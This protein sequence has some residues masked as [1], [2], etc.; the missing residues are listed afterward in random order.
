MATHSSA[1]IS[2]PRKKTLVAAPAAVGRLERALSQRARGV[3]ALVRVTQA[4]AVAMS[5]LPSAQAEPALR[6]LVSRYRSHLSVTEEGELVYAF[7]PRLERRDRISLAER[8]RRAGTV[9]YA[10]F[11]VAFKIWIMV[12]LVAYVLAFIAMLIGLTLA[13]SGSDDRDDRRGGG[14][15]PWIWFWLMPDLAP[16]D[17]YGRRPRRADAGPRKR[18]YQS[19]FDFVFGPPEAPLDPRASDLMLIAYLRGH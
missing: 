7:D 4:D 2:P 16:H 18:F 14:G 17:R 3:T 11:K 8:A 15:L 12:T 10:G 6:T 9:A 5:G 1:H 19:I 13:R